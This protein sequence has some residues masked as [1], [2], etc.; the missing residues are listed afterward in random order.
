MTQV[1]SREIPDLV[2]DLCPVDCKDCGKIFVNALTGH[3]I[4][5]MCKLCGHDKEKEELA[6]VVGPEASA[7]SIIR[8]PKEVIHDDR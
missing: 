8:P 5:C 7:L 3:C 6:R 4:V 2:I 1:Y